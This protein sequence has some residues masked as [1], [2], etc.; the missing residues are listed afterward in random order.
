MAG[1][2]TITGFPAVTVDR[3]RSGHINWRQSPFRD[4]TWF[5]DF[6]S[7]GWMVQLIA[8]YE[9]D[10]QQANAY[11]GRAAALIRD[12][13]R[14][15]P[16]TARDPLAL[17]CMSQA[18][19]GQRWIQSQVVPAVN[20]YAAN[21]QG[22]WNHGLHQ[23]MDL[24]RIGCG[25]PASAFGGAARRW[26]RTAVRQIIAAFQRNSLGPAI[27]A[28]GATNEQSTLYSDYVFNL[29]RHGLPQ[30]AACGYRLPGW[31]MTR[32]AR[33]QAFL[34]YATEPNGNLVQLGDTYVERSAVQ[35]K[36]RNLVAVYRAGYVFGRSSWSGNASFYSLRFGPAR[37]IHGHDDHTGLTYFARGHDLLVNA[38]HIGYA[39]TAYRAFLRSPEASSDLVMP[40]VPFDDEAPTVM[41]KHRVGRYQQF[42][43]MFDT[44]FDGDPRTRS[45]Y[46]DQRPDLMLVYDQG[47][48]AHYYQQL[49]H[50]APQL[51][52]TTLTRSEAIATAPGTQ[53]VIRQI[54]LPGESVPAGSTRVLRARRGPYQGWF[55]AQLRQRVPADVVTM[56]RTGPAADILTLIVPSAPHTPV[57]TSISGH[58]YGPYRL[59]V[60]IGRTKAAFAIS[61][62]GT[63]SGLS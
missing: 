2:L 48:G 3:H 61:P 34:G 27:D 40:G 14:A 19:P 4:P 53:L 44:A 33:L 18:F 28:Q 15:V 21:W 23:D 50:L 45:V 42:Y 29:W 47:A 62:N 55:S 32:I 1:R 24:L 57:T 16:L 9:A 51:R 59:T 5:Q 17:V 52:V 26:R 8:A 7:G 41:P 6:Q 13:L 11:R 58:R 37:Q 10:G 35:R 38:G 54:S 63:I 49:W 36:Q 31:I 46:V 60:R 20:Y 12:W 30:L 56:S 43:E 39:K 22:A 25:Y